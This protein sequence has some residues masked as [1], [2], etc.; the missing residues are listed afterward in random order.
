[1]SRPTGRPTGTPPLTMT[2]TAT[3]TDWRVRVTERD[4]R[5]ARDAWVRARDA[6]APADRVQ[7]LREEHERLVRAAAYQ[8]A[9][10]PPVAGTASSTRAV[11][12]WT[13]RRSLRPPARLSSTG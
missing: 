6:G 11:A 10:D 13:A 3:A 1:M 4:L 9:G 12:S 7:D 5:D 8:A 2:T